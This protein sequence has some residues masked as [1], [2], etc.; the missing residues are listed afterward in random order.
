MA[1]VVRSVGADFVNGAISTAYLK[2]PANPRYANDATV[3]RYKTLLAQYGPDGADP[4]NGFFYYG[5]AKAYDTVKLL[6][7]AGKNPTRASLMRATQKMNWV[8]PY[9]IKGVKVKT[10][11]SDRF[12]LSQI[13]LI[14]FSNPTWNEFG[15][16][17]KGR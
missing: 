16:L 14:R 5:F 10:S 15:S 9:T 11:K 3:K 6:Q 7:A 13:K 17:I 1:A 2:N 4:N 12:P 8:N